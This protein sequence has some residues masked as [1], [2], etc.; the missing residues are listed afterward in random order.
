MLSIL[1]NIGDDKGLMPPRPNKTQIEHTL[2]PWRPRHKY[3]TGVII[4]PFR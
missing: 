3:T 2:P 4:Y 1:F